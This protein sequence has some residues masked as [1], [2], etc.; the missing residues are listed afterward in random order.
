MRSIIS[1]LYIKRCIYYFSTQLLFF[2][3]SG[4]EDVVEAGDATLDENEEL[5]AQES[6]GECEDLIN[7]DDV[8]LP[9]IAS[10]PYVKY[11]IAYLQKKSNLTGLI[12]I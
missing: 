1:R 7:N 10:D 9:D 2:V 11:F 4:Y 3:H 8:E 5:L 12:T 6:G